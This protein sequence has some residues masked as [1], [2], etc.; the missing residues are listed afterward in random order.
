M[1]DQ[2]EAEPRQRSPRAVR[3]LALKLARELHQAKRETQELKD[4]VHACTDLL[5]EELRVANLQA[6]LR[7]LRASERNL[8][9]TCCYGL[10]DWSGGGEAWGPF[11]EVTE[12]TYAAVKQDNAHSTV[13][14][15][16]DSR[17]IRLQLYSKPFAQ[18]GMRMAF[19]A[20]DGAGRRLVA[21]RALQA[22]SK[23]RHNI[24]DAHSDAEASALSSLVAQDF[25]AALQ[26]AAAEELLRGGT[27]QAVQVSYL[28]ASV[29]VPHTSGAAAEDQE[30][31]VY[32]LEPWM[33][34]AGG[35]WDKFVKNDGT[36]MPG[37]AGD[38]A[39]QAFTHFS[40]RYRCAALGDAALAVLDTQ[41]LKRGL[42]YSLTDP[43]L[44]TATKAY[45]KTD[46]GEEAL[47][48]FRAAHT[49]GDLCARVGCSE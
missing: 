34:C 18:G 35:K 37:G 4:E 8:G 13:A 15:R 45:G 43:A 23:R 7:Q 9:A 21:K 49:C 11:Q 38:A 40:M 24:A 41:G 33:D 36:I 29:V 48:K 27:G 2:P 30:V 5:K 10:P 16:Y 44:A 6:E 47:A 22:H 26:R 19:Y 3:L 46:L 14:F 25:S 28:S 32:L 12:I 1:A 31:H 17:P 42:V 20:R 39:V